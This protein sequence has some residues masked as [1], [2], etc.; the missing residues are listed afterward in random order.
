[1]KFFWCWVRLASLSFLA[2]FFTTH[3]LFASSTGAEEKNKN[4]AQVKKFPVGDG[5]CTVIKFKRSGRAPEFLMYDAGSSSYKN[6]SLFAQYDKKHGSPVK[7]AT[8]S[9]VDTPSRDSRHTPNVEK[10]KELGYSPQTRK[11]ICNDVC[12]YIGQG[13]QTIFCKTV[14]FSHP[15]RDHMSFLKSLVER[16]DFMIGNLILA[17]LP[18][19]YSTGRPNRFA[20]LIDTLIKRGT[21]VFLPAV[22]AGEI[23]NFAEAL[24]LDEA[25][26]YMPC[27]P[28]TLF[29]SS[30]HFEGALD[31]GKEFSLVPL[32][33]NPTHFGEAEEVF[34]ASEAGKDNADSLV[35]KVSHNGK[36]SLFAGDATDVTMRRIF[37]IYKGKEHLL[38][39]DVYHAAHH[40]SARGA[41]NTEKWMKL[42]QPGVIV[43]DCGHKYLHPDFQAIQVFRNTASVRR[44]K[45]HKLYVGPKDKK[46]RGKV[47]NTTFA[48]LSTYN[49]RSI[50]Y[51]IGDPSQMKT[52]ASGIL[53]IV[54]NVQNFIEKY[55]MLEEKE[56]KENKNVPLIDLEP[57]KTAGRDSLIIHPSKKRRKENTTQENW[58]S[59]VS[60]QIAQIQPH[61]EDASLVESSK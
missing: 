24:K 15:D 8:S 6:E 60:P 14:I 59:G 20:N 52:E 38:K 44:T 61:F 25:E 45:P 48:I 10:A 12:D 47:S 31:F 16:G 32:A 36:S 18:S 51:L 33:I 30:K 41:T 42:F 26:K 57:I 58:P 53:K 4:Y 13:K 34:R 46:G 54:T 2:C 28:G 1:M 40:A 55:K 49:Q 39:V 9:V 27:I 37:R 50:T 56:M 35:L 17:G 3:V 43:I 22:K 23:R 5:G 19:Q 11:E 21:K 29:D 7:S